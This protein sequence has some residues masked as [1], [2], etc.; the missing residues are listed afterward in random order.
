METKTQN[1]SDSA[2]EKKNVIYLFSSN[3]TQR[4]LIDTLQ[5][6]AF[7]SGYVQHYRY[8]LKYIEPKLRGEIPVKSDSVDSRKLNLEIVVCYLYQQLDSSDRLWKMKAVY[9][10]RRGLLLHCHKTGDQLTDIA[11]FYFQLTERFDYRTEHVRDDLEGALKSAL[12]ENYLGESYYVRSGKKI[13]TLTSVSS[14]EESATHSFGFLVKP[15]H[16]ES[17][18]GTTRYFPSIL[19]IRGLLKSQGRNRLRKLIFKISRKKDLR[20]ALQLS[21]DES[22]LKCFYK[23]REG[24]RYVFEVS[25]YFDKLPGLNSQMKM[26]LAKEHF[27]SPAKSIVHVSSRYDE[28]SLL[29]L[30]RS[31]TEKETWS[32][33]ELATDIL[34]PSDF[35]G[36]A[37]NF[38]SSFP[39]LITRRML[40]RR[41]FAV[42]DMLSDGSLAV[43]TYL[44][45]LFTVKQ[46]SYLLLPAFGAIGVWALLK[47][48][49]RLW[50]GE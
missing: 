30:P 38:E 2:P 11:H 47:L 50:K 14:T 3:A 28:E 7:P 16:W 39:V 12:G 33:V 23:L 45:T 35:N 25:Y 48:P 10:A 41:V 15:N 6:L 37:T 18:D 9:P 5:S 26:R 44:V 20:T 19:Y 4:Y 42:T 24:I 36:E 49:V 17:P 21:I 1:S 32:S 31:L 8:Q 46:Q 43:A 40:W 13:E 27:I 22:T 34:V 29:V